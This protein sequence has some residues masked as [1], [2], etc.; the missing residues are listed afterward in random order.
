MD[1]T[2]KAQLSRLSDIVLQT[3][4]KR[5]GPPIPNEC[6]LPGVLPPLNWFDPVGFSMNAEKGKVLYYR[7][8][9]IKHG[10][11]CMASSLGFVVAERY[12]LLFGGEINEPSLFMYRA[13]NLIPFWI[14]IVVVSGCVEALSFGRTAG[15]GI[16]KG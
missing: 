12:H 4:K 6:G 9:E 8:A 16:L 7:E 15:R 5:T 11:V 13:T 14:A 3:T 1:S 10:R 2:S